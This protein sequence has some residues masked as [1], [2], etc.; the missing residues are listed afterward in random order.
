MST[1]IA[2][3]IGDSGIDTRNDMRRE[4]EELKKTVKR[5]SEE[6]QR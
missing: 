4:L 1:V 5:R 6:L 3:P 2:I